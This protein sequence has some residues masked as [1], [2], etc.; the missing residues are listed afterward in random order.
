MNVTK[1]NCP[2]C[3]STMSGAYGERMHP[4]D[5]KYG[6]TLFCTNLTCSSQEVFG[7]SDNEKKA[8]EVVMA[9]YGGVKR[10]E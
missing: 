6:Y 4:G 10:K 1:F 7:H 2:I 9:K 5:E 3:K 8:Y